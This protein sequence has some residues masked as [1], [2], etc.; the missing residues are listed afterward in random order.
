MNPFF[1][2]VL[3]KRLEADL[4]DL[5][6]IGRGHGGQPDALKP[7]RIFIGDVP[8]KKPGEKDGDTFPCVVLVSG[9]GFVREGE[10]IVT[11]GCI[12]AVFNPE[13]T[14]GTGDAEGAEMDVGLL[15]SGVMRSLAPCATEPLDRRFMLTTD[16]AARLFVWERE[17]AQPR[18]YA[19]ATVMTHWRMKSFE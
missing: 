12:C 5:N 3:K 17:A 19:Q 7:V 8:P 14:I 4:T 1:L 10:E 6:L 13:N 16:N 2:P 18:P 11:V 9:G 15:V